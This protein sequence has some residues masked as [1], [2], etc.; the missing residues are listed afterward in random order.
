MIEQPC[1]RDPVSNP[2]H[3]KNTKQN[4]A[5]CIDD[6]KNLIVMLLVSSSRTQLFHR[7][8]IYYLFS[9]QKSLCQGK[10]PLRCLLNTEM[11]LVLLDLLAYFHLLCTTMI[12]KQREVSGKDI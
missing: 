3:C 5:Y 1:V 6:R 10:L 7:S 2:Q 12:I 8:L 11:H 9:H 4:K